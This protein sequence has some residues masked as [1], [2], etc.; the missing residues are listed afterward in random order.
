[1]ARIVFSLALVACLGF[2]I[3]QLVSAEQQSQEV[4]DLSSQAI[5]ARPQVRLLR[6]ADSKKT[7][8]KKGNKN[9]KAKRREQ[10]RKTRKIKRSKKAV[11]NKNGR[12]LRRN[13][14]N[15]KGAKNGKSKNGRKSRKARRK[16][17]KQRKQNKSKRKL[18]KNR[19][20]Q[21][22]FKT[23]QSSNSSNSTCDVEGLCQKIKNYIKYSNQLRKLNRINKTCSTME[24]K[25]DKAGGGEFNASASANSDSG[26]DT[27][28]NL[29]EELKNCTATAKANCEIK[30]IPA[31]SNLTRNARCKQEL[32]AWIKKFGPATGSCLQASKS[33]CAC[34]NAIT[35]DP[36]PDC[37][38]FEALDNSSKDSKKKCTQS[39][40]K[41]SFAYCRKLQ[42]DVAEKGPAAHKSKCK[43][44]GT[45]TTQGTGRRMLFRNNLMKKW[46]NL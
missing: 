42:M 12:K 35:P 17:R 21:Q 16:Q 33:C 22:N 3:L 29:A 25:R 43:S 39:G 30:A 8:R 38:I 9:G 41:G 46:Y 6:D 14:K 28:N 37:L 36:S 34:I 1:M 32:G 4:E 2:T 19:Q 18:R 11:K 44:A 31:C 27:V 23:R 5:E 7:T 15:Q 45:A 20:K 10:K 24:K 40:T 26:D 13:R